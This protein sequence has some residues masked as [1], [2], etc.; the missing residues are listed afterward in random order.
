MKF[1][2]ISKRLLTLFFTAS[3]LGSAAA[4]QVTVTTTLIPPYSPYLSDYTSYDKKLVVSLKNNTASMLNVRLEGTVSGNGITIRTKPGFKPPTAI[5]L[6]PNQFLQLSGSQMS[7][8]FDPANLDFTGITAAQVISGNG[9]PE[10]NYQM[11]YRAADYNSGNPLSGNAPAGCAQFKITHFEA[12]LVISPKC[13][14]SVKEFNP[15]NVVFT[16][17]VPAGIKPGDVQYELQIAEMLNPNLPPQ[18]A[19]DAATL[20][21][22]FRKT[23]NT[24]TYTYGLA[25]PKLE[26]GRRYAFRVIAK[27]NQGKQ[28]NFKNK[29]ASVACSFVY[30]G[31]MQLQLPAQPPKPKDPKNVPADSKECIAQCNIPAPGSAN[32]VNAKPGDTVMF[33]LFAMKVISIQGQSGKGEISIPFLKTRVNVSFSGLQVNGQYQAY[34]TS[35]ATADVEQSLVDAATAGNQDGVINISKQ[36]F[37]AI[38]NHISQYNRVV[39]AFNPDMQAVGVPFSLDNKGFD[40]NIVGLIFTPTGAFMN[41]VF[42]LDIP[43]AMNNEWLDFSQ[44]GLCI[45]PYGFGAQPVIALKQTK[46]VKLS[47]HVSMQFEGGAQ[48]TFVE[49]NC[50]GVQKVMVKGA[51]VFSRQRLLPVVNGKVDGNASNKVKAV[52]ATQ[53][54]KA[55][56][57]LADATFQPANFTLAEAND[58][59]MSAT[60]VKLDQSD[61]ANV[62]GMKFHPQ[63]PKK[64]QNDWKGLYIQKITVTLPEAFTKK[65][66]KLS[67][68]ASGIMADKTGMWMK[69]LATGVL[70]AS[71]GTLANWKFGIDSL[72]LEVQAGTLAGG[73]L[74]GSIELPIAET[75]LGCRALI[76][77]GNNGSDFLFTV[78]T[79]KS[80]SCNMWAA[81]LKLNENS[82]VSLAKQNGTFTPSASLNGSIQVGFNKSPDKGKLDNLSFPELQFQSLNISNIG[83]GNNAKPKV[84]LGAIELGNVLG[85]SKMNKLPVNLTKVAVVMQGDAPGISFGLKVNLIKSVSA[86][87]AE[88]NL[89]IRT[90]YDNKVKR[91]TLKGIDLEKIKID[92]DLGVMKMLGS[93]EIYKSD[94]VYGTGFRGDIEATV[95]SIGIAIGATLQAGKMGTNPDAEDN[96]NYRYFMCDISVRWSKGGIPLPGVPA[97]AFYGFSG[98]MYF[99]MERSS[100]AVQTNDKFKDGKNGDM[101]PGASRS[102]VVYKPKK[103]SLGFMAG[104]TLG[105]AGEATAF[106]ADLKLAIELKEGFGIKKINFDGM[107]YVMGNIADRSTGIVKVGVSIEMD[108]EKPMFHCLA[109][110]DAGF[111]QKALAVTVKASLTFHFEPGLW[112]VKLGSWENDDEPWKDPKRI[113]VDVKADFKLAKAS[114]NF[115]TYFM[116]G[117]DIGDL[118]R[119]PLKVRQMLGKEGKPDVAEP[120]DAKVFMGKGFAMGAGF[121]LTAEFNFAVFYANIEAILGYDLLLAKNTNMTCNGSTKYGLNGWYAK[122]NAY[123]YLDVDAGIRLNLWVWKGN[124]SLIQMTAA[125]ELKAE[126]PNPSWMKGRFAM[127]GSVL[128]GLIKIETSFQ[129]EMGKKCQWGTT[130]PFDD[131]PIISDIKPGDGDNDVSV[132]SCPQVAFNFNLDQSFEI[133]EPGKKG[134]VRTFKTRIKSFEL[135]QANKIQPGKGHLNSARNGYTFLANDAFAS[136]KTYKITVVAEGLERIGGKWTVVRT[137]K[138]TVTFTTGDRPDKVDENNVISAYPFIGQRYFLKNDEPKGNVRFGMGQCYLF[139]TKEDAK[140]KFEYKLRITNLETKEVK[141]VNF[142]CNDR[143]IYYNMPDLKNSTVHRLEIVQVATPKNMSALNL[144]ENTSKTT[145][146]LASMAG[147]RGSKLELANNKVKKAQENAGVIEKELMKYYFRTSRYNTAHEK[148]GNNY[149]PAGTGHETYKQTINT[150]NTKGQAITVEVNQKIPFPLLEGKENMDVYDAYGYHKQQQDVTVPPLINLTALWT[151]SW[152]TYANNHVYNLKYKS[153]SYKTVEYKDLFAKNRYAKGNF[154]AFGLTTRLYSV[155]PVEAMKVWHKNTEGPINLNAGQEFLQ[156]RRPLSNDEIAQAEKG[157]KTNENELKNKVLPLNYYVGAIVLVDAIRIYQQHRSWCV[158]DHVLKSK[159]LDCMESQAF[160]KIGPWNDLRLGNGEYSYK[161]IYSYESAK[162]FTATY[163]FNYQ[164]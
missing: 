76:Q 138:K 128:N 29:G 78:S 75:P 69:L 101:T 156:P 49:F 13:G 81:T 99:N 92:A 127:K 89:A 150:V 22:F 109:M 53:I 46:E 63:H 95:K 58:F 65:G 8:Y 9:L 148:Y 105:M 131:Y 163:K 135:T 5:I 67:V 57:W 136:K 28:L 45:R 155:P 107:G 27:P 39:S 103:G 160:K 37:N 60:G 55:G 119:S 159:E 32:P 104:V 111:D 83:Q 17:T 94:P 35:K 133:K 110:I 18:Q 151:S 73:F 6:A 147:G 123:A 48:N 120:R 40:L 62:Q 16:W 47:D 142:S 140:F 88:T 82:T 50:S 2:T 26:K 31:E 157:V 129:L 97:I 96:T 152:H 154:N 122:G 112:Y 85:Q 125:A 124:F 3:L 114:I 4:Q 56:D 161:I 68:E 80:I 14:S 113:Q 43:E 100:L 52:F 121:R 51:Y 24:N 41:S 158:D 102:G 21:Y 19:L 1:R 153:R 20:P 116:M 139:E 23:V 91:F 126:M 54:S 25:D 79:G 38:Q 12:P 146:N 93:I 84:S 36:Q 86:F 66:Q 106:N 132:F 30:G 77:K 137:E 34:G 15:Q 10:G 59:V 108:F 71:E 145:K 87:D 141:T 7:A 143:N 162:P 149:K 144:K 64:N 130:D 118:P 90:Q 117:T 74:S 33:G 115:N 164:R 11:C 98:G 61:I 70:K 42:S 72:G 44:K 134:K